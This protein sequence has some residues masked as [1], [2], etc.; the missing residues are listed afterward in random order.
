MSPSGNTTNPPNSSKAGKKRVRPAA[1]I[2]QGLSKMA[3][4]F[5]AFFENTDRRMTEI[6][7]RIGYSHDLSQQRRLVNTELLKLP[8]ST[9]QRNKKGSRDEY[10]HENDLQ[11][12]KD[13]CL[14]RDEE[15]KDMANKLTDLL[16]VVNFMMQNN[17]IQPVFPLHDTPAPTAKASVPREGQK[18]MPVVL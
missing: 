12:W 7:H 14:R 9:G 2:S 16:T 4:T 17:V 6:A 5:G 1:G 10:Y 15:L 11:E 18:I 13:G 8:M 3:V